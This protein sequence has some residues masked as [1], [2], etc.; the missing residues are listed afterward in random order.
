MV[1]AELALRHVARV[2]LAQHGVA[3]ARDDLAGVEGIP[4]RLGDQF[5]GRLDVL[6]VLLL[7][8]HG[9]VEHFL[10]GQAV[11]RAGQAV[12]AGGV[13]IVGVGQ[14]RVHQVG[15]VGRDVAGLV[16][17]VEDEV[18]P[19]HVLVLFALADHVGEVGAHV[20]LRIDGD[21]LVAPVLQVV[22][23]GG[24]DGDAGDDVAGI[25]VDVFPGG[26]LVE[27]AR[28]VEAGE[29]G[30]LLQGQQA[31]GEHDHRV[32]V[33]R[34]GADRVQHVLR[35]DLA[36]LPLGHD[37]VDLGL[38]RDIAGQQEVPE[39]LDGRIGGAGGLGQR[40]EGLGDGL[41]AEADPFLRIKVGD[42]G[43]QAAD[44]AGAADAWSMLTWSMMTLPNSLTSL[45]VRGRNSSIFCFRVSFSAIC[46]L[47]YWNEIN[48]GPP[49]PPGEAA[50]SI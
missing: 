23:E 21:L 44:V 4:Q 14:G 10:V 33:A 1:E 17:G 25:F 50:H 43:D 47:L 40:R 36:G 46:S 20:E 26:H 13:G 27:L 34:Q 42:V 12:E 2:G 31:D 29:L 7:E 35:D 6:A 45:V 16:V 24:D 38:G 8:L 11:Q 9:P 22:D 39:G 30:V 49:D 48:G 41:A 28:V 18:H 19:G 32:A 5:L 15:G 3:V 37:F